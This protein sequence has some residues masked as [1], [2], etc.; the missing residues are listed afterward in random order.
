MPGK[1]QAFWNS[2]G[3]TAR[4]NNLSVL[5]MV[6]VIAH[7]IDAGL[8]FFH[9]S[10]LMFWYGVILWLFVWVIGWLCL[11]SDRNAF[12][13]SG[14][15]CLASFLI[16]FMV[17]VLEIALPK[18]VANGLILFAPIWVIYLY[19]HPSRSKLIAWIGTIYLLMWIA[20]AV[21]FLSQQ[22]VLLMDLKARYVDIYTPL[23]KLWEMLKE[24]SI[25]AYN[26]I[27]GLQQKY[28]KT[29]TELMRQAT[30]DYYTS[31]VDQ[32]AKE[33]LGVFVE[34]IKKN[35][36]DYF[37]DEPVSVWGTITAKTFDRTITISVD[38]L[39]DK[40]KPEQR[41][42]DKIT[43]SSSY[44]VVISEERDLDCTFQKGSF[45]K[46][47]HVISLLIDFDFQT[48]AYQKVYFVDRARAVA[49]A[50]ENIDIL[51]YYGIKEKKPKAI[52]T[53]GP[54]MLG[55][56]LSSA[57]LKLNR[58]SGADEVFTLGVTLKN[59]W[60]GQ[61]L[62]VTGVKIMMPAYAKL[63]DNKCGG[64]DFTETGTGV[65]QLA[66]EIKGSFK[67]SRSLRC[68]V[69]ISPASYNNI[70]GDTPISIQYFKVTA[71]YTY[72]FEKTV[73]ITVKPTEAE[74][75]M[76]ATTSANSPT[77]TMDDW[78]SLQM[79]TNGQQT[80]SLASIAYDKETKPEYLK[81][82]IVSQTNP[83]VVN[84]IIDN[85]NKQLV[86]S[87]SNVDGI[88]DV[89]IRVS[90][91]VNTPTK[92]FRITVG[93]A[94]STSSTTSSTTQSNAQRCGSL[95]TYIT[96]CEG[97]S[98]KAYDDTGTC[99]SLCQYY[100]GCFGVGSDWAC[101]CAVDECDSLLASNKCIKGYCPG[102]Y[103]CCTKT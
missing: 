102:S 79:Q 15:L 64:Y 55:V 37:T 20:L 25:N 91:G 22:D 16:P 14:A 70:L 75:Q 57:P 7:I 42:A 92:K 59:Q 53:S 90:D 96:Y 63:Q 43:P 6:A 86:C 68:Q 34:N 5:F 65:Y 27:L 51:D 29:K 12:L 47:S 89:T 66:S 58:D 80:R 19:L 40:N 99:V 69:A 95:K 62:K 45:E 87:A 93:S 39:A 31:E 48:L 49:L 35:Q 101:S 46:G 77:F 52:Y 60:D 26:G 44:E 61:I 85:Q 2:I 94:G 67:D 98:L 81:Y 32:N 100:K 38:C 71:T 3:R 8:L 17:S 4:D 33:K 41:R 1:A 23:T 30:G 73:S 56:D 18:V 88:S 28:N 11:G 10:G 74:L 36:Q 83:S 103:E 78:S 72:E 50:R 13:V 54:V 97:S 9:T 76:M 24:T 82:T 84:C 21:N